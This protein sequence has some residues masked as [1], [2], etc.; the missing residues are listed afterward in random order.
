ML[1]LWISLQLPWSNG[2][3][4]AL[5]LVN[6]YWSFEDDSKA[7]VFRDVLN[8]PSSALSRSRLQIRIG[9]LRVRMSFVGS[10]Q[11]FKI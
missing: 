8:H 6:N 5:R 11:A 1:S 7:A 2:S 3:A 9:R 10:G 4:Y